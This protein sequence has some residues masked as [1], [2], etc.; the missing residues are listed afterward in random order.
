VYH[1]ARHGRGESG[2]T[3]P[4]AVEREVEDIEALITEP[5]DRRTCPA[6][7]RVVLWCWTPRRRDRVDKLA[8]YEVRCAV[9]GDMPQRCQEFVERL[10]PV[11][12]EGRPGDALELFA[13]TMGSSDVD[14]ISLPALA[15][16]S[17]G[18]SP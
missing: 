10:G 15:P 9:A 1:Y 5:A 14:R 12:A 13:R 6:S 4:F 2:D 8:V 11:L 7:R 18:T 3:P 17:G 16:L